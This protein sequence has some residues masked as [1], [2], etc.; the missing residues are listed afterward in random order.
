MNLSSFPKGLLS[1]TLFRH[2][3]FSW[4]CE[5]SII[6]ICFLDELK[7]KFGLKSFLLLDNIF[8]S[9]FSSVE[10]FIKIIIFLDIFFF[11]LKNIFEHLIII[12]ISF[13]KNFQPARLTI[14]FISFSSVMF[15]LRMLIKLASYKWFFWGN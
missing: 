8:L 15:M 1:W 9:E 4:L 7:C 12:M 3:G 11:N 10:F 5:I 2:Y 6:F 13:L 14:F